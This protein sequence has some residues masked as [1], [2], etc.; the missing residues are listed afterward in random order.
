MGN[1]PSQSSSEALVQLL[2]RVV[3]EVVVVI[4][5]D[6]DEVNLRQIRV[7]QT[8]GRFGD[9]PAANVFSAHLHQAWLLSPDTSMM[10]VDFQFRALRATNVK[11]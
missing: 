8:E 9:S 2:H 5:R 1:L 7:V 10:G 3:V 11:L 6:Y 4:V